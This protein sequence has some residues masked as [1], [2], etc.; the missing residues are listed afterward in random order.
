MDKLKDYLKVLQKHHFW[1]LC[2]ITMIAGFTGW[3]MAR[4]SLSSEFDINKG[5]VVSKFTALQGILSTENHPHA[6]WTTA[7]A[8]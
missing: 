5:K 2:I 8:K 7:Q 6:T 1:L 4:K 3:F